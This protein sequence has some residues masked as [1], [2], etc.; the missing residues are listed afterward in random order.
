MKKIDLEDAIKVVIG[1]GEYYSDLEGITDEEI[2]LLAHF[3]AT[4]ALTL[5]KLATV[6]TID[7]AVERIKIIINNR[8]GDI[9][10]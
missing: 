2:D 9:N 6:E 5:N 4:I 1:V 8:N 3:S 10:E 7:D